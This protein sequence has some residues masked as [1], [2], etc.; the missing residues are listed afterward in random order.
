M[1][2]LGF[3]PGL[4]GG[5]IVL[6]VDGQPFAVMRTVTPIRVAVTD[7]FHEKGRER[8]E[9]KVQLTS[10]G[11]GKEQLPAFHAPRAGRVRHL[12]AAVADLELAARVA[13][14]GR[15]SRP[16]VPNR[17]R[18]VF[19]DVKKDRS[20]GEIERGPDPVELRRA[21]RHAGLRVGSADGAHAPA[22]IAGTAPA[23]GPHRDLFA[24]HLQATGPAAV[25]RHPRTVDEHARTFPVGEARFL[26]GKRA[27]RKLQVQGEAFRLFEPEA[28][29]LQR[30]QD[31]DRETAHPGVHALHVERAGKEDAAL[32]A[33]PQHRD[34]T[35]HDVEMRIDTE[36]T[37]EEP[38]PVRVV[39][40]VEIPVVE[41]PVR[42]RIGDWLGRLVDRILVTPTQHRHSP[43]L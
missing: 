15:D 33:L 7:P 36:R 13:A 3:V 23:V 32:P 43:R 5:E 16:R 30:C 34:R 1:Q 2:V 42:A 22:A 26:D 31:F 8:L 11:M 40:V 38:R 24:I 27:A 9:R 12:S 20:V 19:V 6:P 39:A 28:D 21:G 25:L 29:P 41:V 14:V 37:R 18:P 17:P 10:C 35:V 4:R